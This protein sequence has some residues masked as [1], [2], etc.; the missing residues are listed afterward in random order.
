MSRPLPV[1]IAVAQLARLVGRERLRQALGLPAG[2]PFPDALN[3]D[4]RESLHALVR[5]NTGPLARALAAEAR[6]SD[7]VHDHATALTYLDGRL[8]D[9][10]DLLPTDLRGAILDAAG[11]L[12]DGE[13][14]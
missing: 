4:E 5:T 7:D 9:L 13:R 1:A 11:L 14:A 10:H 3:R 6:A 2:A 8:A 12:T